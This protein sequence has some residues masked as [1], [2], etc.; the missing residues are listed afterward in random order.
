MTNTMTRTIQIR[1]NVRFLEPYRL[2]EW[3]DPDKRKTN[4]RYI[5]GQTFVRWHKNG[6]GSGGG[7]YITGTLLRSA[8][9]RAAEELLSLNGGRWQGID[10]C[11]GR[12][13]TSGE[14]P[15]FI[16]KRP[17]LSWRSQIRGCDKAE[18]ACPFCLLLGRFDLADKRATP[19]DK[20][21]VHFSNF[22]LVAKPELAKI[23]D[24]ACAR[25]LNRVDFNTGKA[26][27]YFKI[28]EVD[29]E[30][31]GEYTGTITLRN[32]RVESL[33]LASLGFVDR[34]CGALCRIEMVESPVAMT[35]KNLPTPLNLKVLQEKA[36]EIV[37]AFEDIGKIDKARILADAIRAMRLKDSDIIDEL[38]TGKDDRGH[39]LWDMKIDNKPLREILK[40]MKP[41]CESWRM[42]CNTL[43]GELYRQYKE[44]AGEIVSRYRVLGE[45]EYYSKSSD[46]DRFIPVTPERNVKEWIVT[47]QLKAETPFFFG[48]ESGGMDQTSLAILLDKKGGYRVPRSVL[49]GALRRDLRLAF[50]SGCDVE[51][52]GATPCECPVCMVMQK[53]TVMD[54]KS[55]YAE[56]PE[57]RHRIRMNPYT[58]VVDE[59]ALFDMEVGPEGISFPFVLR[60]RGTEFPP[61]LSSILHYWKGGIAFLGGSGSTGKGRF[62]L[63]DLKV[64]EW[65]LGSEGL[66]SYID[67][68]GLRGEELKIANDRLPLGLKATPFP[69]DEDSLEPYEKYLKSQ[70]LKVRYKIEIT[71]PL[72]SADPISA[73]FDPQN[74]DSIVYQKRV[75]NGTKID[76]VTTVKG[77]TV[78][79]VVRTAVGKRNKDLEKEHEDCTCALCS[80]FGNEHEIGKIRFEDLTIKEPAGLKHLDRVAIDR[81]HG[82]AEDM[83]K[84]DILPLAG[85]PKKPLVLEGIL[86]MKGN[87]SNELQKQLALALGDICDGLYPLGGKTGA[88]CGWVSKLEIEEAQA[89]FKEEFLIRQQRE[90]GSNPKMTFSYSSI[91][92]PKLDKA[93]IYYPHCFL[94]PS[95]VVHRKM[96]RLV[97]HEKWDTGLVSGKITCRLKTLKPIIIPDTENDD[98]FGLKATFGHKSQ[99]FFR[100][101]GDVMIPGSE[102]RGMIS[103]VYEA[104]TNSCFRILDETRYVSWRMKPEEFVDGFRSG[105]VKKDNGQVK[106]VEVKAYR[107]PIYD[108]L[109]VTKEIKWEDYREKVK[110]N[111][112]RLRKAINANMKIANASVKNREF[113]LVLDENSRKEILSGRKEVSFKEECVTSVRKKGKEICID[114][115]AILDNN[116]PN[117]GFVKFTGP[118]N[119]NISIKDIK[120]SGYQSDWDI[121]NLNILLSTGADLRSSNIQQYPRPFLSFIKGGAEYSISKRCERIFLEPDCGATVYDVLQKVRDQYR[122][123]LKEYSQNREKIEKNFH[124]IIHND[125]ISHG[126]LVYFHIDKESKVVDA[127][128]PVCISRRTAS[129]PIGMKLANDLRPC[130]REILVDNIDAH[131]LKKHPEEKLFRL[132]P[133]GLCPACRL[134][135]TTSYRGRVRFGFAHLINDPRWLINGENGSGGPL[136]LP[137]LERPRPS[138]SMP[139]DASQFGVP[140]R[141]FYF[142]H[143]GWK[144]IRDKQD[145][146]PKTKNNRTVQPLDSGNVFTFDIFFENLQ[147]WELGLLL[148]CLDLEPGMGHKLGMA[149]PFGFGSARI[150]IENLLTFKV[151]NKGIEWR[152]SEDQI[153]SYVDEGMKKLKEWFGAEWHE[154][155]HIKDLRSLLWIPPDDKAKVEYPKLLEESKGRIPGYTYEKLG[156]TKILLLKDRVDRLKK[157]WTPWN[158]V[159]NP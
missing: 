43:G 5:R 62:S 68:H 40:S 113:L 140:G 45:T 94:E 136:T 80:I 42:F 103:Y 2:V 49:R 23:E 96:E 81:F 127:V 57:I 56:P 61:E 6:D 77:E 102:I 142:H 35:Y 91:S 70:W 148:H 150:E 152:P 24:I 122:D 82:G 88:G 151:D 11:N 50:D 26:H 138:W 100:I 117:K 22:D 99:K 20:Y 155:K 134:F 15:S 121:W 17:T 83:M 76:P 33:L 9:I 149:K 95:N 16:R 25:V 48:T 8:V 147:K 130:E 7:P 114:M 101:S 156:D 109:K 86:W 1:I 126:D 39:Y 116:G 58:C 14:K 144:D 59:G 110:V 98:A 31:W 41:P 32:S 73:L 123:I 75:W 93:Q 13:E 84:F 107:L 38:P 106:I 10:C 135:G 97:G 46:S 85:S 153:G 146:I 143:D 47:G 53:I 12:F 34:L 112:A 52:G 51:L 132:H 28:W 141:K 125:E 63:N 36:E 108:D 128:I 21:D 44:R 69:D 105:L 92:I 37:K 18:S 19:I 71:S 65:D 30:D 3:C 66:N 119:A 104:L 131:Q 159:K 79:G 27:D 78:R 4:P 118:N 133:V 158:I 157:P 55:D 72:I 67:G 90:I 89:E 29:N 115:I 139:S 124:T 60:Y 154:I 111:E 129:E 54:S 87:L 64:F 145:S 137:L 74:H 120:D